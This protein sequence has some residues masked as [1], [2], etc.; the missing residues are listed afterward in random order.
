M[1]PVFFETPEA[2]R[3][4]LQEHHRTS[5][6]L[7]VGFHKRRKGSTGITWPEAVDQALCFG[8]IDGVRKRVDDARYSIRFTPRR[9]G[10]TWSAINTAR[11]A[12]LRS[13]GLMRPAGAKA[14]EQRS[15]KKSRTY[16][17]EQADD[18]TLDAPLHGKLKGHKKAW[19][20]FQAQAPSYRRKAIH[21]VVGAK[22]SE[23][24]LARLQRLIDAFGRG[25]RL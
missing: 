4:W 14:F 17:Y 24:R 15:E 12:Q 10:S 1:K 25:R 6:E 18:A 2:F 7:L 19:E 8:W 9:P 23:V 3:A 21:W 13:L 22:K 11:V 5:K 20:F 16:S